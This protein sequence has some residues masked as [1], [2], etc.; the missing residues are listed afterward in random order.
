MRVWTSRALTVRCKCLHFIAI[1]QILQDSKK[2]KKRWGGRRV[3]DA[4]DQA[5]F[6][7]EDRLLG[8]KHRPPG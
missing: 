7:E 3:E 4:L 6:T 5:G 2:K 8:G 1:A